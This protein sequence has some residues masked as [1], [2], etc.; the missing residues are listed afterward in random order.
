MTEKQQI[1]Y[2][3]SKGWTV[4]LKCSSHYYDPLIETEEKQMGGLCVD[5]AYEKQIERDCSE[6]N[7]YYFV[8]RVLQ[9]F[10]GFNYGIMIKK[11][12]RDD[13]NEMVYLVNDNKE[14]RLKLRNL[15][16][17]FNTGE[18][19]NN[20]CD[21][22]ETTPKNYCLQVENKHWTYYYFVP[23][24]EKFLKTCVKIVKDN[25]DEGFYYFENLEEIKKPSLSWEDISKLQDGPVKKLALDEWKNYE[26]DLKSIKEE[27]EQKKLLDK[28]LKGDGVSASHLLELRRNYEYEKIECIEME[29]IDE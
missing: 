4:N 26:Y 12:F 28:A 5:L 16:E 6:K 20:H 3:L 14:N 2:I 25:N 7:G 29:E 23:T 19:K 1:Q 17:K 13:S 11:V 22:K 15:I 21:I 9:P 10:L 8:F 27:L 18:V 24:Y